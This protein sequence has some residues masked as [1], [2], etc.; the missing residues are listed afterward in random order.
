MEPNPQPLLEIFLAK[1]AKKVL[2]ML[3]KGSESVTF[4]I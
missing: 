2:E 4:C 3:A 1:N